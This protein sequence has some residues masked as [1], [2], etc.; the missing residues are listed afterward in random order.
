MSEDVLDSN[1]SIESGARP[2]VITVSAIIYWVFAGIALIVLLAGAA[3]M[4]AAETAIDAAAE[5][6]ADVSKT[7]TGSI[8]AMLILAIITTAA[9]IFGT[10]K[11]WN[12]QKL[13]FFIFLGANA[14]SIIGSLVMS[15]FAVGSFVFPLI[16]I[17]L[18][19]SQLKNMR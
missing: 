1:V 3:L 2:T 12:M 13:G 14:V 17:A 11:M 6:G 8:W 4:G 9:A 18:F 15:G 7:E 16:F 19:G 10:I 5:Q